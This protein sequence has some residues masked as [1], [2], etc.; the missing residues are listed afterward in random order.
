[1]RPVRLELEGFGAF[2]EPAAVDFTDI[3]LV[4][5]V[6]NTGAGKSTLIDAITFALYGS[7]SRYDDRKVVAPIINQTSTRARVRL[8]FELGD[9]PYT[10]TRL[11]QRTPKGATTKEARLERAGDVLSSDARG[12]TAEVTRLLGLD[13]DQFNRTVV[14]PQGRFADFLHDNPADRQATLRQL[15]GFDIYRRLAQSARQRA[16]VARNQ[17]DALRPDLTEADAELTDERRQQL[18]ARHSEL[19]AA[20]ASFLASAETLAALDDELRS[21]DRDLAEV[22]AQLM[23]LAEVRAPD[24]LAELDQRAK[25]AETA[26]E[27]STGELATAQQQRRLVDEQAASG[28][29][30]ATCRLQLRRHEEAAEALEQHTTVAEQLAAAEVRRARVSTSAIGI[31]REQARLDGLVASATAGERSARRAAAAGPERSRV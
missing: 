10:A 18:V 17:V 9:T 22:E 11:V 8:D 31:E 14:L 2:R 15:L 29:D 24:G 6:G 13:V 25:E 1:M 19:V 21:L 7:V 16:A 4:A 26:V 12:V 28:P 30:L 5:F 23:R 3:E 20:R 27:R